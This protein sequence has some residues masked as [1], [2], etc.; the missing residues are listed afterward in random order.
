M[1]IMLSKIKSKPENTL[2]LLIVDDSLLLRNRLFE[3]LQVIDNSLKI[4]QAENAMIA[5]TKFKTEKPEIIV[6]D[7]ALPDMSGIT[8]LKTVKKISPGTKVIILTNYPI[9]QFKE[10]CFKLGADYFLNK[11]DEF[12]K[13]PFIISE[14]YKKG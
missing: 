7:I 3:I 6:L 11:S 10:I 14:I 5:L 2:K 1:Q 4:I 13:I 9:E 8:V 12:E